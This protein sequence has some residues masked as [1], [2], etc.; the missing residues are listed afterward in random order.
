M[1]NQAGSFL[2]GMAG[3]MGLGSRFKDSRS[4]EPQGNIVDQAS[5]QSGA[6]EQAGALQ[7]I[8]QMI[9]TQG[10]VS[11]YASSEEEKRNQQTKEF[12]EMQERSNDRMRNGGSASGSAGGGASGNAGSFMSSFAGSVDPSKLQGMFGGGGTTAG[13]SAGGTAASGGASTGAGGGSGLGSFFGGGGGG[14]GATAAGGSASGGGGSAL[15]SAGPWAALV[16]AIAVNEYNGKEGGYR[17]EDDKEYATDLIGG[18]VLE[19]DLNQRWLPK[20]YGEDLKNDKTGIGHE[21]KAAGEFL[22]LDFSNGFKALE[23]GTLG[24]IGKGIKKLF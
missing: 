4:N 23:G 15:A 22:T 19:Q 1:S 11:A 18:K 12:R 13:G 5:A 8:K 21:Q 16:A 10:D 24:K 2:Q 14:G 6:A 17:A 20:I 3:G 9:K 7:N